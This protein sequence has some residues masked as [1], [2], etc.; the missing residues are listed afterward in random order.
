M[1]VWRKPIQEAA[2]RPQLQ[3]QT[4]S[5][6]GALARL[7]PS[8]SCLFDPEGEVTVEAAAFLSRSRNTPFDG[9][10]LRG[11]PVATLL[12]GR[13]IELP[14]PARKAAR[15]AGRAQRGLKTGA[16]AFFSGLG[17]SSPRAGSAAA[18]RP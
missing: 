7:L 10:T 8:A 12:A 18:P 14:R 17:P 13:R 5:T 15:G 11:R 16:A 6:S 9:W 1:V 4:P 2:S 3:R